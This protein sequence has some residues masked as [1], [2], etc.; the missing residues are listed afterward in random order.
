MIFF[1]LFANVGVLAFFYDV[2]YPDHHVE[3]D[4]CRWNQ[5]V[6]DVIWRGPA[7]MEYYHQ[8]RNHPA[9]GISFANNTIE[10]DQCYDC[11]VL[12]LEETMTVHY[13]AC[14]KPW[15]C[16]IPYPRVPQPG[17]KAHAYRLQQLTNVTTCRELLH[18]YFTYRQDVET[19]IA[20]ALDSK[21]KT[22]ANGTFESE[23]F[24]G[25]CARSGGYIAMEQ[26]P[27]DFDM[28][29]VYGF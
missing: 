29:Q 23:T 11:R 14:K 8:C 17:N 15:E 4:V 1:V 9:P 19:R 27:E 2:L 22:I 20:Q 24:L 3:L 25:Y 16:R 6:A 26:L 10:N 7:R 12:P 5:V 21:P 18:V 28:K 13:T